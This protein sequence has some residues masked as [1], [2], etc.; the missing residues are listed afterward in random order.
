MAYHP[1]IPQATDDPTNSQK[2][3]LDNFQQIATTF[4]V[5]HIPLTQGSHNGQH[6]KIYFPVSLP[7]LSDP[8]LTPNQSSL[9]SKVSALGTNELFYQNNNVP[10]SSSYIP[11][12]GLSVRQLTNLP[13]VNGVIQNVVQSGG[14]ALITSN[15]HGIV[16]GDVGTHHV[17]FNGIYGATQLNGNTYLINSRI[18]ANNFTVVQAGLGAYVAGTG[19]WTTTDV[20]AAVNRYGIITP[21]NIVMNFGTASA[22]PQ[23]YAVPFASAVYAVFLQ[24]ISSNVQTQVPSS[25]LTAFTYVSASATN[26]YLAIGK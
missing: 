9:Y 8:N 12:S 4:S 24:P 26:Y 17:T 15:N 19:F 21:W 25:T 14:N 10:N 6:T 23:V 13:I 7:F 1:T 18:D 3:L 16:A 2:D 22:S 20:P 5:N 11:A